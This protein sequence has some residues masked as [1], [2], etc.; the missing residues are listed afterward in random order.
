MRRKLA[1]AAGT[2]AESAARPPAGEAAA[3]VLDQQDVQGILGRQVLS[4][5]GEDMGRVIDVVV[6]RA[7]QVRA[8]VIDFGGF[9][10]VG[11]R[12]VAID[13]GALRFAPDRQQ[14]RPDHLGPDPRSGE[15]GAGIQG[16][17]AI[18]RARALPIACH[19]R[20]RRI[21]P[22]GRAG[23]RGCPHDLPPI[24][25]HAACADSIGSSSSSP[26]C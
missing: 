12:K 2:P 23:A 8:A 16:R 20:H 25:R 22:A 3:T 10:G 21:K 19:R 11:N 17:K 18:G 15:G 6:D 26:T 5:A 13:W 14:V 9:L 4:A 1:Q 24:L 7:G